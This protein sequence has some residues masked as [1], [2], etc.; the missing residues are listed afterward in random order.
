MSDLYKQLEKYRDSDYYPFH[1]PGHKRIPVK[2]YRE[3]LEAAYGIDITEI[4]GFDNL[5]QAQGILKEAQRDAAEIYGADET[6][7][8]VNGSTC[9]ILSAVS[10]V[11]QRGGRLLMARNCHKSV[12]YAVY[13][14]EIDVSYLYPDLIENYGIA[15]A[16]N[17]ESLEQI[18]KGQPDISAVIITSPTYEG[19]V[20]DIA[21]IADITHR[22]GKPLI[23]DEAHGAHFGFHDAFPENAVRQGADIVIHSVH[24]T[25]PAMTQT[26]LLHVQGNLV[27]RERLRRYLKVFQTS[28]PSYVLMASIDSCMNLMK[29]DGRI[30][31]ERLLVYRNEF[32]EKTAKCRFFEIMDGQV[33]PGCR[34]QAHDPGKIV[35]FV[36]SGV[37]TGRQ[38]Y[39]ILRE[40]YHLQL[41]MAA[42]NYVLAMLTVMDTKEGMRRLSDA[43]LEIDEQISSAGS[44]SGQADGAINRK[45]S[46]AAKGTKL[47][48]EGKYACSGQVKHPE[49]IMTI[50]KAVMLAE[51]EGWDTIPVNGSEGRIAAEFVNLYPPGIPLAVPGEKINSTIVKAVSLSLD[52]LLNVQGAEN[53]KIKVLR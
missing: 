25:L 49:K 39:D 8:L 21:R 22:Y 5:H 27:D 16:V 29:K 52:A 44:S 12:Y 2:D 46:E 15:D 7:F 23:V 9:G 53:G 4:D 42:D 31:L 37:L 26:A 32:N 20:S 13:L 47:Q 3:A 41:E 30:F 50:A 19:V 38:L 48:K 17:P 11:A 1:M 24:K 40:K 35:I 6:F 14:Q 51:K 43:I 10:A 28:S 33:F 36:K 45:S 34:M 18:L